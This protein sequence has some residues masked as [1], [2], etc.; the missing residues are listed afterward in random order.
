M[1]YFLYNYV[2]SDVMRT[3]DLRSAAHIDQANVAI[4]WWLTL[5]S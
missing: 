4:H 5:V 3:T 2:Y 1:S